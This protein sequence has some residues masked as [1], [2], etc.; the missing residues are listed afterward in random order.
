MSVIRRHEDEPLNALF[1]VM[2]KK[3]ALER[4][5]KESER[6]KLSMSCIGRRAIEERLAE[7]ESQPVE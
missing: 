4:L 6:R 2:L 3:S 7:L 5:R 1:N